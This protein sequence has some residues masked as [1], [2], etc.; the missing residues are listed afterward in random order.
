MPNI[1]NPAQ[2]REMTLPELERLAEELRSFIL[3]ATQ[4]KKGHLES[5]LS[6]T[7][8]TIALHYVFNTPRDVLIWDVGHQAYVHK[9]LTD[10]SERFHTNRKLGGLS[11]FPSRTESAYDA[12]GTGHSSTSISAIIGMAIEN[13]RT[14]NPAQHIAVIG[15]G[16]ITGGMAYEALNYLGSTRLNVLVVLNDNRNAI[17]ANVGALHENESYQAF[18]EA[19]NLN[20]LGEV[21]GHDLKHLIPALENATMVTGPKVL[22]VRTECTSIDAPSK[23]KAELPFHE[24]FGQA[25][26]ELLSKDERITV[27]SPAMLAGAGLTAAH[28]TYPGRVIDVGIA[29]QH[30]ATMAAGIAAAGGKPILHLYSTFAQRAYDQIIHDIALQNLPVTICI[31]RA[32]L[33]GNDGPTHHGAFDLAFLSA[34][35]NLTITAPRNGIELRNA[36]YTSLSQDGPFV[37]RYPRDTEARFDAQGR[38]EAIPFGKA[39]VLKEGGKLC[40]MSTGTMSRRAVEVASILEEQ[41]VQVSILHHLFIKPLDTGAL[42]SA[43]RHAHWLVLEDSS[44]GGLGSA[45]STWLH[46]ERIN[47]V[48]LTQVHL[49]DVFIEHGSVEELHEKYQMDSASVAEKCIELLHH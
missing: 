11:G 29:E 15:D 31:D 43:S 27:I 2:L 28:E 35:P 33:V 20:Y 40:I 26:S 5:S 6:V 3:E 24:V 44:R 22:R 34:I 7:E 9:V 14:K 19:L 45:L 10:R 13:V 12:F 25:V 21:D 32:G 1:P 39:E 38:F 8:L 36:L 4:E 16:A 37:I 41:G 18:F 42:R 23:Y 30:A 17:D 48:R 46:N 49:P 47:E